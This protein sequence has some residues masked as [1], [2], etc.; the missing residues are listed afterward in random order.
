MIV[1][2]SSVWIDYLDGV[3]KRETDLLD[4]L[5]ERR[6]VLMGDLVFAEVLQGIRID[7]EFREAKFALGALPFAP[8]V[9]PDIALKSAE[10]F[11]KL[12]KRGITIR[13]TIDVMIATFCIENGHSLLHVDRDFDRM[14]KPLG[15][16]VL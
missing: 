6:T 16:S 1:A 5:L 12:R 11:R 9:G 2:D 3:R 7:R 15:L 8:M 4:K 10:N 13:K 14:V